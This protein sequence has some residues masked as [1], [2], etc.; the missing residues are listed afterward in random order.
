MIEEVPQK[1][2][3]GVVMTETGQEAG[4]IVDA[5]PTSL[6]GQFVGSKNGSKYHLPWC[7]GAQQMKEENKVWFTD[8]SAAEVAGYSPA[9]NCKGI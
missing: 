9:G 7:P 6:P 8:K 1:Q 2:A 3:A 4:G 5:V